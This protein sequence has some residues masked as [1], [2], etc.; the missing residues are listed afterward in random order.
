[1]TTKWF[2]EWNALLEQ[3][4][5]IGN[6]TTD[7][8]FKAIAFQK[9]RLANEYLLRELAADGFLPA[10][11]FPS[12]VAS[13]DNLTV[14]GLRNLQPPKIDGIGENNR[15]FRRELAS[16]DVVTALRE[17]AP[18][19]EIVLDGLV[20][21]SAGITL[22]WHVPASEADVRETQAIRFAWWCGKCGSSGTSVVLARNCDV[23]G[24]ELSERERFLEPAGFSVDFYEDPHNNVTLPTYI[25]VER[26]WVT[27]RGE[28]AP[29][30]NPNL[31]RYRTTPEGRVYHHSRGANG[32]GYAICLVCG[33][34]EPNK[35][36]GELPEI[37]TSARGHYKLRAKSVDR[38]CT[39]S[40]NRWA[41]TKVALGHESR[42][43]ML[44]L[45][46][47]S[48]AGQS[49]TDYSTAITIAVAV[50]DALAE[51]LGIQSGELGCDAREVRTNEGGICQTIFVF[52]HY[53]AGYASSA[54]RLLPQLFHKAA[55]ILSCPK[56]CDS[57]CP[58]CVLDFDQRFEAK[59]LDRHAALRLLNSTWLNM[60]KLPENLSYWGI[61][62]QAE[63]STLFDAVLRES[64]G[65]DAKM[66][67]LFTDGPRWDF[68]TSAVRLLAY[69]LLSMSRPVAILVARAS[70]HELS[71]SD[72]Y[73]LA[74]IADH[75]EASICLVET[76]PTTCGA[77]TVA[78]VECSS[79]CVA[80]ACSDS[81]AAYPTAA[82]G[83]SSKPFIRGRTTA[84]IQYEPCLPSSLRPPVLDNSDA[85][86]SIQHQLDGDVKAFGLR[87]WKF[88]GQFHAA[89]KK[90]T[91]SSPA[92]IVSITYSDRYLFTPLTIALLRQVLLGLKQL[93]GDDR[94]GEPELTINT[95]AV[96]HEGQRTLG[97]KVF[98]DWPTSKARDEVADLV[99][100]PLG[101]VRIACSEKMQH[102][103]LL[104]VNFSRGEI[105]ALRFDQGVGYWRVSSWSKSG[106][107]GVSFDFTNQ[108][109]SVQARV[110]SEMDVW[111]EG[112]VAPTQVFAKVRLDS[113]QT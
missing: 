76:M 111:I 61:S 1:V 66:T 49:I 6:D 19:A 15:Y 44:E 35:P 42:T 84:A 55:K 14:S 97:A 30:P 20:Y 37:F 54:E 28:W 2:S 59:T 74:A 7:P 80:W 57:S 99:L 96:R 3:E 92:T 51:L 108:N 8:A 11:G 94:Y 58:N 43:D 104:T 90:L 23:C 101:K 47:R 4:A 50:R 88:V 10:Y 86:I 34:A 95:I 79:G 45:Q 31:G 67:R 109:S 107:K 98:A 89:S 69:K 100:R 110:V 81:A 33:R 5:A 9:N 113:R 32:T 21:R 73:S 12:N 63:S 48:A 87:L 64:G 65:A 17:Y 27:A 36:D 93:V 24:S 91:M 78:E 41:I 71:E 70:L 13:F 60:F 38:F 18:G 77:V 102:S 29:L 85:E 16:R 82:W 52:D 40:S 75:P 22:N 39:G 62:S 53:A 25:P 106:A 105:L 72:R 26:P 46:L 56:E 103:R 68:A 83:T 112:Q